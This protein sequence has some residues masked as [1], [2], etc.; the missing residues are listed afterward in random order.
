MKEFKKLFSIFS[1]PARRLVGI[2][3]AVC[4]LNIFGVIGTFA[5]ISVYKDFFE[6]NSDAILWILIVMVS[7][8]ILGFFL[9]TITLCVELLFT[10]SFSECLDENF[11]LKEINRLKSYIDIFSQGL[12][13]LDSG[14]TGI[15]I[16]GN[17]INKDKLIGIE[18]SIP[19][20][21]EIIILSSK[22]I[23]D[24]EYKS[25]IIDN[26]NKGVT[27]KYIVAGAKTSGPS[28]MRFI[29]I[30]NSWL[31]DFI[32]SY[33]ETPHQK[34]NRSTF[35]AQ[36]DIKVEATKYFYNH[37]KEYNSPFEHNTLTIML[38]Q[39]GP[40]KEYRVIVNLPAEQEGYYSYILPEKHTETKD[41]S[42]SILSICKPEN[43]CSY[44]GEN[45]EY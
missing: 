4:G 28:H 3:T 7:L 22:Y 31:T 36:K 43:E 33:R 12:D 13:R 16:A 21:S 25:I 8:V 24:E 40:G 26:I 38:Y 42:N 5:F 15:E 37:V 1:K 45:Y 20:K 29:Q 32:A 10:T 17:I 35:R 23:L 30:V 2:A 9:L 18:R 11:E 19:A 41:I 6:K 44:K 39:K 14:I 34:K 27:Y